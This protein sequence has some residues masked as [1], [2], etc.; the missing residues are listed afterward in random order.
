MKRLVLGSLLIFAACK[1]APEV[2]VDVTPPSLPQEDFV[3]VTQSLTQVDI[4]YT[5]T[6]AAGDEAISVEKAVWEF[7]VDGTIKRSGEARLSVS[8]PAGQIVEFA[9]SESLTYVKDEEELK[10]MDARGGSLL[11]AMRG[12]LFVTVPVAA[13]GDKPASKRTIELPLLPILARME[14]EG[15]A[16]NTARLAE[17]SIELAARVESVQQEVHELAGETFNINSPVQLGAILFDKL[18]LGDKKAKSRSTD[19]DTLE[20]IAHPIARRVLAYRELYKLKNTYVDA[21]PRH[22][23]DG[24]IHTT[25]GQAVAATGRLSSTDPNLQN[26][27]I[28]TEDGKRIRGCFEARPGHVLLS[29]D[30][31]QIELRVLAHYCETGPLVESCRNGEDIHRRTASEVFN[32]HPGLVTTEM[33][34]AA[35]AINFGIVYGMGAF[36]LAG[37]L[38]IPRA[39]AAAY[40][41]GYFAR[42]PQVRAYM[43]AATA[44]ARELGHAET[45]YGRKRQIAGLDASSQGDRAQAERI[46]INTPIQGTAADLIKLAMIAVDKLLAGTTCRMLLQVHDE[47]VFELPEGELAAMAPRIKA[48]MEGVAVLRVPLTVEWGAGPTWASAH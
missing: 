48:A 7:V 43:E 25:Y 36:R 18:Q 12:T 20:K 23:R 27:P 15:I 37:E 40:I 2:V 33:R 4:K 14:A 39:Q 30:Y 24:R 28:R 19:A 9:L 16:C 32:V 13:N 11:L 35:K 44:R 38:G 34:R 41:E 6:I 8:A 42:Y 10:A 31:S 22:V 29:C 26:I 21:L 47:L 1:S 46:A 3:V 17:I 45:L 5:G